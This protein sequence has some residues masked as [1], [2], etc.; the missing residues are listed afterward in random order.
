MS[1]SFLEQF[2]LA[3]AED[4]TFSIPFIEY[5]MTFGR[6]LAVG[7]SEWGAFVIFFCCL[8]IVFVDAVIFTI[9]KILDKVK[10]YGFTCDVHLL[11]KTFIYDMMYIPIMSNM[12][13][14]FVCTYHCS[15]EP[16][17]P[18]L[19]PYPPLDE[20]TGISCSSSYSISCFA[21]AVVAIA[22]FHTRSSYFIAK[23]FYWEADVNTRDLRQKYLEMCIKV[24]FHYYGYYLF[25]FFF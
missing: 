7:V 4:S 2:Q 25:Y 13:T 6:K 8:F 10:R 20:Y 9:H 3:V 17:S 11:I 22:F 18:P 19:S 12:L 24:S 15:Y 16:S 5:I 21:L 1:F 23:D 14:I